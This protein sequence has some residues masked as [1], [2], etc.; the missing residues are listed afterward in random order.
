MSESHAL[1]LSAALETFS[2]YGYAKTTMS[3]IAAAAQLSRATVYNTFPNKSEVLRAAVTYVNGSMQEEV[4][5]LWDTCESLG[6]KLDAFLQVVPINIYD[7]LQATPEFRS[8]VDEM[9][10]AAEAELSTARHDWVAFLA[11]EIAK[12]GAEGQDS[13]AIADFFYATA[14]NSKYNAD[15]RDALLSRLSVLKDATIKLVG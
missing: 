14:I 2:K 9:H 6:E 13:H 10:S 12:H 11:Q 1:L 3:D 7:K 4:R 8:L 15:D 5:T